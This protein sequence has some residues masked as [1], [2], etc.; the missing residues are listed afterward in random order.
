[1]KIK[2]FSFYFSNTYQK[3]KKKIKS[4]LNNLKLITTN[5]KKKK[6]IYNKKIK[7]VNKIL[8]ELQ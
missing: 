4:Y 7:N 3:N 6:I 5:P 1:M 2:L 8:K